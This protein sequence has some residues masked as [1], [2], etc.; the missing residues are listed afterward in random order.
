MCLLAGGLRVLGGRE[1][2]G[3]RV[4]WEPGWKGAAFLDVVGTKDAGDV[5]IVFGVAIAFV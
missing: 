2:G 4:R 3:F 5:R 1:L